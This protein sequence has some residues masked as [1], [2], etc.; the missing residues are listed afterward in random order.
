[1]VEGAPSTVTDIVIG[2]KLVAGRVKLTA[3]GVLLSR[4]MMLRCSFYHVR[5]S[6]SIVDVLDIKSAKSS[7]RFFGATLALSRGICS[8][9][10]GYV[11]AHPKVRKTFIVSHLCKFLSHISIAK[12]N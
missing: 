10:F 9:V 5:V 2:V 6:V 1:V 11:V 3:G 8:R 4:K 7:I 12:K